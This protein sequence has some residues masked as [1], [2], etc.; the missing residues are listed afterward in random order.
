MIALRIVL[1]L[2]KKQRIDLTEPEYVRE[3]MGKGDKFS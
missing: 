3:R 2:I 1:V